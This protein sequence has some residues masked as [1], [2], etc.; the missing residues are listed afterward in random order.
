MH[1]RPAD[2]ADKSAI[3]LSGICI[4]H[5]LLPILLSLIIPYLA[6]LSFLTDEAF[7]VWTLVFIVPISIFAIGWGF[8]QHRNT[9]ILA[10]ALIGLSMIVM[11]TLVGHDLFGHTYEVMLTIIG[12]LLIV[13]GHFKNLKLRKSYSQIEMSNAP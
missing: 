13:Y 7:H 8:Y 3:V 5:C 12:S 9:P 1:D 2:I 11:A 6:G 10:I 4:V